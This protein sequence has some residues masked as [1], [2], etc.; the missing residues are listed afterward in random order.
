MKDKMKCPECA[1]EEFAI[2]TLT[3]ALDKTTQTVRHVCK[4]ARCGA[5]V[6]PGGEYWK[7]VNNGTLGGSKK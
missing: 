7:I 1:G 5:T 3:G 2:W 4:C 6:E